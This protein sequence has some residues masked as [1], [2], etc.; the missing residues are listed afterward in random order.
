VRPPVLVLDGND[1]VQG[2]HLPYA[3]QTPRD[4]PAISEVIQDRSVLVAHL[5]NTNPLADRRFA[6]TEGVVRRQTAVRS[7]DGTTVWV[8][9][10]MIQKPGQALREPVNTACSSLSASSCTSSQ[11]YPRCSSKNVSIRRCRRTSRRASPRPRS[12][13]EAPR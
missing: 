13:S 5:G 2:A 1:T 12:V 11:E 8:V 10:G 9:V 4:E 7:R 3:Q 6:E